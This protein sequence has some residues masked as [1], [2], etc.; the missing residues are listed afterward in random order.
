MPCMNRFGDE[1]IV[2]TRYIRKRLKIP[3]GGNA[4]RVTILL[5]GRSSRDGHQPAAG[6]GRKLMSNADTRVSVI[7]G[8]CQH[9][10]ERWRDFDAI[11]RPM[12]FSFLRKQG[13]RQSEA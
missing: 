3:A 4:P 2:D 1:A 10:P 8:V 7:F 5:Q 6:A 9:D 11:Y 13:L 12:L